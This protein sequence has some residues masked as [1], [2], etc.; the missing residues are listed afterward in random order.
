MNIKNEKKEN[1]SS[2]DRYASKNMMSFEYAF[3]LVCTNF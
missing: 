1:L 2:K 3:I